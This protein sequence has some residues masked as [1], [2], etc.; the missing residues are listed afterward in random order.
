MTGASCL[1]KT[2][3]LKGPLAAGNTLKE[4]NRGPSIFSSAA[5]LRLKIV[6]SKFAVFI[7]YPGS[8][9]LSPPS[10][11]LYRNPCPNTEGLNDILPFPLAVIC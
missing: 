2:E 7:L 4:A 5:A 8:A 10:L 3:P 1:I 11:S 6:I 9:S